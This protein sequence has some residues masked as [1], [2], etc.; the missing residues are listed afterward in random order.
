MGPGRVAMQLKLLVITLPTL[1]VN[2]CSLKL[3]RLM[4]RCI[5]DSA[6]LFAASHSSLPT[7]RGQVG[8]VF[9]DIEAVEPH[10]APIC[11]HAM[12]FQCV[13]APAW[14]AAAFVCMLA[15]CGCRGGD[16]V[17]HTGNREAC[18]SNLCYTSRPKRPSDG[19][20]SKEEGLAGGHTGAGGCGRSAFWR[21]HIRQI[22]LGRL[23]R[24]LARPTERHLRAHLHLLHFINLSLPWHCIV[25]HVHTDTEFCV[26]PACNYLLVESV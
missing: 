2:N 6:I 5:R 21:R 11:N 1:L 8:H 24:V 26:L 19:K 13:A 16:R 12:V 22:C 10:S 7:D 20:G 14:T 18:G 23:H 15:G 9:H 4:P 25:G 17:L 3:L